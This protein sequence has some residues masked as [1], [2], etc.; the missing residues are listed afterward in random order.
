M[1]TFVV[2]PYLV[3]KVRKIPDTITAHEVLDRDF[4]QKIDPTANHA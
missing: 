3:E 4:L 1:R 2:S